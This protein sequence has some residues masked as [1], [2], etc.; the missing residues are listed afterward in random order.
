MVS[1]SWPHD[2]H[3]SCLPKGWDYWSEPLCQADFIYFFK[4]MSILFFFF[5][6]RNLSVIQAGV[7]WR[8]LSSLQSQPLMFKGFSYFSLL[9]SWGYRHVP[10]CPIDFCIF[11]CRDGFYH[12]GQAGFELLTSGDLPASVSQSAGIT[13]MSHCAQPRILF[14]FILLLSIYLLLLAVVSE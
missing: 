3:R 14:Y 4:T 13:G 5:R 11:F 8:D 9:C 1:I 12:V 2:P 7:Q 6:D 10:P